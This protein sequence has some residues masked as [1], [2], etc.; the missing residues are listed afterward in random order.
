MRQDGSLSY[1][2]RV[3]LIRRIELARLAYAWSIYSRSADQLLRIKCEH[4]FFLIN[5][6]NGL[7][8]ISELLCSREEMRAAIRVNKFLTAFHCEA[9]G[10]VFSFLLQICRL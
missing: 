10:V 6:R 2:T 9:V 5:L 3:D 1:T 8:S 7:F 4:C